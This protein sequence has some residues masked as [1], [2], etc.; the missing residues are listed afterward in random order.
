[1]IDV[2]GA[3]VLR[4]VHEVT[5]DDVGAQDQVSDELPLQAYID[6]HSGRIVDPLR[7]YGRRRLF[8]DLNLLHRRIGGRQAVRK[9]GS[10]GWENRH[11]VLSRETCRRI[12][13]VER[14]T[15]GYT[16]NAG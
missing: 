10:N 16:G 1:M 15:Y 14:R 2:D 3:A 8:A 12:A 9:P 5:V 6:V 11:Q 4:Y 13:E 7:E